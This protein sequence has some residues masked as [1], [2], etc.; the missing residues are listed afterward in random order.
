MIK[1]TS[2]LKAITYNNTSQSYAINHHHINILYITIIL[3]LSV[4]TYK[5]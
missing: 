4:P 5:A 3:I 1:Y 2:Q